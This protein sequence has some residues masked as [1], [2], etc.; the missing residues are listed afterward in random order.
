M[1]LSPDYSSENSASQSPPSGKI[2]LGLILSGTLSL[3]VALAVGW[4]FSNA[5]AMR[6]PSEVQSE[7]KPQLLTETPS[8]INPQPSPNPTFKVPQSIESQAIMG[9]IHRQPKSSIPTPDQLTTIPDYQIPTNLSLV[10]SK[11]EP[12]NTVN[13]LNSQRNKLPNSSSDQN[14]KNLNYT[15]SNQN[16]YPDN[17]RAKIETEKFTTAPTQPESQG[18]SKPEAENNSSELSGVTLRLED[19]I[20]LALENNR[21]IKNQYLERIVQ[22]QDLIVAEDKFV[23]NFTP[24]IA[25]DWRNIEQG[26]TRNTT[27]G[28]VLSAG[29]EMTI[30]TGGEL[31]V[32]WEGRR[33]NRSGN[34]LNDQNNNIFRQNLELSFRQPLLRGGGIDLNQASIKI[35]RI[36]ETI[37]L[38]DL[39]SILIDQI[40]EAIL[41]YRRLVQAQEQLKIE[42]NSLEIAQQQVETTQILIDAGRRARVDLVQVQTRVADQE[43][44]VLDAENNLQQQRLALLDIL[45]IDQDL[46]IVALQEETPIDSISLNIDIMQQLALENRPDYL[47]AKLDVER[48]NFE[49][50]VAENNRRWNIDLTTDA[51]RELAPDIVEDRT[52]VRA[53]IELSKTLGDRNIEREFKRRQVDLVQAKNELDEEF[54]QITIEVQNRIRE[55]DNNLRQ[56]QLAQRATQLAE[57][58][59]SNEQE[60]IQLGAGDVSIVDLV[61]FQEDL[62]RARNRE[63]NARISYIN[64]ITEL[65]QVVG[66]TLENWNITIQQNIEI[67]PDSLSNYPNE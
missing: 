4:R 49:L 55:V 58:Q 35:A 20:F 56:V 5:D 11:K 34:N 63:L 51:S 8:I 41:A 62:G 7:T 38:L 61:R 57:E 39:K 17:L 65:H 19:T 1:S 2:R 48:S 26:G 46:N 36:E 14:N 6:S 10:P 28:A 60:K 44:N 54:Q 32:G 16:L 50:Q 22:Q 15:R 42:Q 52:E 27:S 67:D 24:N 53:G 30:P 25:L 13:N 18:E 33:E 23:P 12:E 59:F 45:D 64:S 43:I 66:T 31:N 37:N 29:L 21:N 3:I 9:T 47:K 40:T